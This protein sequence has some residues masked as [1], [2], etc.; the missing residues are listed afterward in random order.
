MNRKSIKTRL[1]LL[2][3]LMGAIPFIASIIFI[4][5]R[6]VLHLEQHARVEAWTRNININE[7]LTQMGEKNLFVL[8][9]LA[10]APIIRRYLENPQPE[11]EAIVM[12]ML[13]NTNS[14][15]QDDNTTAMTN[16]QGMQ[17]LRTDTLPKV[18]IAQRKHFQEAM[19]GRDYISDVMTSLANGELVLGDRHRRI[20]CSTAAGSA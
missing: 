13:R 14:I 9:T 20:A 6:N 3:A 15:F 7:H 18:N 4:G 8:R 10:G 17:I 12:Q 19:E 2:L 1:F 5:W 16:A 11:D